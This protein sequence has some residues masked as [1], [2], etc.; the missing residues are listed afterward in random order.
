M[1][2]LLVGRF[3]PFHLGHLAVVREVRAARAAEE[4]ILGIGSAQESYTW[5]N[6]FTAAER[7]EMIARALR[8]ANVEGV[9]AVPLPD[10]QRHALWVRYVETA[11]PPF[12]QVYTNNPLTRLLFEQGKYSVESPRLVERER[13]EGSNVR[14]HLARDTDWRTLVPPAVGG[15]LAE[16]GAPARLALLRGSPGASSE[17]APA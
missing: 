10:I 9:L 13:L 4:L 1:R 7:M 11:L 8:E 14:E 16:L 17:G 6:P 2:G 12:A 15:Y 5:R 3:Q